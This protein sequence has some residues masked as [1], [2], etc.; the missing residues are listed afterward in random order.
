MPI[1]LKIKSISRS[2]NCLVILNDGNEY[3]FNNDL[4]VK[5]QLNPG[6][7]IDVKKLNTIKKEQRTIEAKQAAYKYASYKPRTIRQVKTKLSGL[8]YKTEEIM[9]C[10][11]FLIEFGLLNDR[12]FSEQYIKETVK[13]KGYGRERIF[14]EL[15]KKGVDRYTAI[16]SLDIYF[17]DNNAYDLAIKS[18]QKKLP[19]INDRP[20]QKQKQLLSAHLKRNG[21]DWETIN[22]VVNELLNQSN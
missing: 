10:L 7:V 22:N 14:N 19:K 2:K 17:P 21:F 5:F 3:K 18:A 13:L 6:I 8:K 9:A 1:V 4:I 20:I 16:Q 12:N 15:M 11:N